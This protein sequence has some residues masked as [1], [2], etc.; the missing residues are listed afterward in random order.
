MLFDWYKIINKN[1]FDALDLYS[2]EKTFFMQGIGLKTILVTKG[3]FYGLT[4]DGVFL[5]VE[6]NNKNPFIFEDKA[7]YIDDADDI[8]LGIKT[9]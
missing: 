7:T 3:N 5:S 4:Y 2:V 8:W 9:A 1:D 6:L